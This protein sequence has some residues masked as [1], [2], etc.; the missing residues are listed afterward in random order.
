MG[1]IAEGSPGLTL[2][3]QL[4]NKSKSGVEWLYKNPNSP[5]NTPKNA[6]NNSLLKP[7]E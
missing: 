7:K 1:N 3:K 6:K 5:E 2:R 4:R